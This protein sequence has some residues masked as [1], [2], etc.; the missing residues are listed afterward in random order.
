MDG[1]LLSSVLSSLGQG[2]GSLKAGGPESHCGILQTRQNN[3][4]I[5]MDTDSFSY[6]EYVLYVSMSVYERAG[7]Q[8]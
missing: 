4:F 6:N 5:Y 1:V 3:A 8:R 2:E 7:I